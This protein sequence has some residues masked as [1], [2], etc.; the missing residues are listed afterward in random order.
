MKPTIIIDKKNF[1][2]GMSSSDHVA[3]AGFS[4]KS[5]GIEVGALNG[6]APSYGLLLPGRTGAEYSTNLA[7]T[8]VASCLYFAS[9][10]VNYFSVGDAGKLYRTNITNNAHTLLATESAKT[11]DANSDIIVYNGEIFI[12]STTDITKSNLAGSV[13]DNVWWTSTKSKTAL[14]AGVPHILFNYQ[15]NLYITDGN[16]IHLWDGSTATEAKLT[17]P[18]G[19][20]ITSAV[21]H[22]NEIYF[23]A[24]FGTNNYAQKTPT[25]FF[26]WDGYSPNWNREMVVYCNNIDAAVS[27][28]DGLYFFSEGFLYKTDGYSYVPMKYILSV[29]RNWKQVC[30]KDGVIYFK[31]YQGVGAYNPRLN[32]LYHP[33]Y[34]ASQDNI[35]V[36]NI[37]FVSYIDIFV[38]SNKYY[39]YDTNSDV[40]TFYSNLYDFAAPV[41]V[42]AV[43]V[44][45][46]EKMSANNEYKLYLYDEAGTAAFEQTISHTADGALIKFHKKN[47][48]VYLNYLQVALEFKHSSCKSIRAIKIYAEAAERNN[49][50]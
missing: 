50:K 29:S 15:G 27:A 26:I 28:P 20:I 44:I 48:S 13:V 24:S 6:T 10:V 46:S 31:T 43:E 40:K 3:D 22:R 9:S 4:P 25:N 14:T 47:L 16:K 41:F 7:D 38:S 32:S 37:S 8:V 21:I 23:G 2:R 34:L 35:R 49:S 45:F 30:V 36:I 1:L 18:T 42:R 19:W 12:T 33:L 11:Y 5:L 39:R 17:L